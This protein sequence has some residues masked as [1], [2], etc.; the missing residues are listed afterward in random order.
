M[1]NLFSKL[2]FV[3]NFVFTQILALLKKWRLFAKALLK[4]SFLAFSDVAW[5]AGKVLRG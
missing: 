5:L 2:D 1:R 4:I 3:G